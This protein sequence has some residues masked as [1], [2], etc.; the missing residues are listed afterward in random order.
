ML[1]IDKFSAIFDMFLIDRDSSIVAFNF[2]ERAV[3]G[4]CLIHLAVER[5]QRNGQHGELCA[6]APSDHPEMAEDLAKLSFESIGPNP[7]AIVS[8]AHHILA[9]DRERVSPALSMCQTL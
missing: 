3:G 6:Q 8:A 7:A 1:L 2:D 4:K 9:A 5:C